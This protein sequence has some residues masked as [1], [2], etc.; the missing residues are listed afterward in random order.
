MPFLVHENAFL[1]GSGYGSINLVIYIAAG[2]RAIVSTV[3]MA[4]VYK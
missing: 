2:R 4:D 3:G 1:C